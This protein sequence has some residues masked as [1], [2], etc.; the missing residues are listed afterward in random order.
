MKEIYLSYENYVKIAKENG[1]QVKLT[2]RGFCDYT[3]FCLEHGFIHY[4]MYSGLDLLDKYRELK[5]QYRQ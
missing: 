1:L 4:K 5:K 2:Y 3:V